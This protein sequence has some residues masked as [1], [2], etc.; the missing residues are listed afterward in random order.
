MCGLVGY[1]TA[2]PS[3]HLLDRKKF[4]TQALFADTFRGPDST[5]IAL[6]EKDNSVSIYKKAVPGY[7]FVDLGPYRRLSNRVDPIVALG[8]NRY[9]TRG[10]INAD[11]AHPFV[12]RNIVLTHNGTIN[13]HRQL[14]RGSEYSV[15]SEYIAHR[16]AEVGIE[17]AV[18]ELRGALALAWYDSDTMLVHFVRN[19]DRELHFG[20]CEKTKTFVYASEPDLLHWLVNRNELEDKDSFITFSFEEDTLYTLNPFTLELDEEKVEMCPKYVAPVTNLGT[21]QQNRN[22]MRR[23]PRGTDTTQKI[24]KQMDTAPT[25][26]ILGFSKGEEIEITFE[27]EDPFGY[28]VFRLAEHYDH[29]DAERTVIKH[30]YASPKYVRDNVD[31][32][33]VATIQ[34]ARYDKVSDTCYI[35]INDVQTIKDVSKDLVETDEDSDENYFQGPQGIMVSEEVFRELSEDGCV[36]CSGPIFAH[37][38]KGVG[39][40][41]DGYCVCADCMAAHEM[42]EDSD[43]AGVLQ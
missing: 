30:W 40:T 18:K 24:T 3:K 38:H 36:K 2:E 15:D 5:G 4:F 12:D 32:L 13:N 1:V 6:I 41:V 42:D 14:P 9:A 29:K 28:F 27:E 7:D 8:H 39:W 33:F 26:E 23:L 16:V 31:S 17:V 11:T 10:A 21:H 20:W 37:T 25:L 43:L 35:Y 34:F 22:T 19:S